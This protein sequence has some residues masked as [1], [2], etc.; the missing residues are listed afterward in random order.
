MDNFL[1]DKNLIEGITKCIANA[2][3]LIQDAHILK[4]NKKIERAYTLFQ[5]S[6]EEIGKASM[7]YFFATLPEDK[8]LTN[9]KAFKKDFLDH[10]TKTTKAINFDT[11]IL[12]SIKDKSDRQRFFNSILSE[13]DNLDNLNNLKN[14][15]LY[16]SI[17]ADKFLLPNEI[18]TENHLEGI[19]IRSTTRLEL[20][21]STLNFFLANFDEIKK[22][23][24]EFDTEQIKAWADE[25][26]VD[27]LKE[28]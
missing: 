3:S 26:M 12:S 4:E 7:V 19:E 15:S 13:H 8:K 27:L 10:K 16:T 14:Y 9:L 6:L 25:F 21:K 24:Q 17:I 1:S 20:I 2:E 23:E 5:L 18:I 11:I 28:D 22:A